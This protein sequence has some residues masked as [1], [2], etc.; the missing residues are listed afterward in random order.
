MAN[1]WFVKGAEDSPGQVV[2]KPVVFSFPASQIRQFALSNLLTWGNFSS[3]ELDVSEEIYMN[4]SHLL[5][6]ISGFPHWLFAVVFVNDYLQV[7]AV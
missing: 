5:V 6:I 4:W 7:C 3:G 1:E 2:F